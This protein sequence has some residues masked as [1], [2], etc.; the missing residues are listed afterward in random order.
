LNAV[1][2]K[3]KNRRGSFQTCIRDD[4]KKHPG[5]RSDEV[6]TIKKADGLSDTAIEMK[7][8][9]FEKDGFSL[10]VKPGISMPTGNENKC[11]GNGRSTYAL[12]LIG[13]KEWGHWSF[14]SNLAYMRNENKNNER[15]DIWHASMAS[16][17]EIIK[18]LKLVGDVGVKTYAD[19][20]SIVPPAYILGGV[21]FSPV[22]SFDIGLGVKAGLNKSEADISFRGGITWSF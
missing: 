17:L 1:S 19:K 4:N 7:W 12:N 2:T 9:F 15:N 16:I 20:S 14:H 6:E 18:N 3:Q 8:R 11:L 5:L 10:A 21:I 13:S 22:E